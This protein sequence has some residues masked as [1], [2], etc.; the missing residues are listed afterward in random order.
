MEPVVVSGGAFLDLR[1]LLGHTLVLECHVD[2]DL[3]DLHAVDFFELLA[4]EQELELVVKQLLD[5]VEGEVN[6]LQR[7]VPANL[8]ASL[9]QVRDPIKSNG[10]HLQI[11]WDQDIPDT[12][13]VQVHFRELLVAVVDHEGH[14]REFVV[15]R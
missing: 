4:F 10:Q 2:V 1:L 14:V 9:A 15:G 7:L 3:G 11:G 8:L 12:V 13:V 6:L 5:G